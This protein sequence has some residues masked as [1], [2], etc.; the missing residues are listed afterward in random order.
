L[1][2]WNPNRY[3]FGISNFNANIYYWSTTKLIRYGGSVPTNGTTGLLIGNVQYAPIM[4]F[5]ANANS[6]RGPLTL[7][8]YGLAMAISDYTDMVNDCSLSAQVL[9][10]QLLGNTTGY[11]QG[12]R[13]LIAIPIS[14]SF[15]IPCP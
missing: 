15:A 10:L 5:P 3:S 1:T 13:V 12:L 14:T 4:T 2:V 6:T 9:N 8:M 11:V 7:T